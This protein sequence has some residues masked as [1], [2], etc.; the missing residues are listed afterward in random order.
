MMTTQLGLGV[1][2]NEI[3]RFLAD[4]KLFTPGPLT[5]SATVKSA[6][7]RDLGSRDQEFIGI[8][9]SIRDDLLKV[10][11]V[12]DQDWTTVPMQGSGTFSVEAVLQTA[13]PRKNG[14]VSH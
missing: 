5:S 10:A 13:T 11:N 7:L 2:L 8:V 3:A 4:K 14:R 6:M 1:A 12:Q 9:R